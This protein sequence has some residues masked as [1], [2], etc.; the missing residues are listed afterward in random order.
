[1]HNKFMQRFPRAYKQITMLFLSHQ[2]GYRKMADAVAMLQTIC[3]EE[4]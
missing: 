3:Q 1:M 2:A 4:T